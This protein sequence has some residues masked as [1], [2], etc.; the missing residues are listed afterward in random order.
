M[1][2]APNTQSRVG[3]C[4]VTAT[5][6]ASCR[7]AKS[8]TSAVEAVPGDQHRARRVDAL[9]HQVLRGGGDHAADQPAGRPP[10]RPAGAGIRQ[11]TPP[12]S[13]LSGAARARR[14]LASLVPEAQRCRPPGSHGVGRGH[15]G[16]NERRRGGLRRT[17][18]RSS[19][20]QSPRFRI[21]SALERHRIRGTPSGVNEGSTT[22]AESGP[23]QPR[24]PRL[25]CVPKEGKVDSTR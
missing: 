23:S 3:R 7:S 1:P 22:S 17:E 21:S 19:C 13:P 11:S 20:R 4:A 5:R 10:A 14:H 9:I 12:A 16:R 2:D 18:A 24:I 6:S 8:S 25:S 15:P